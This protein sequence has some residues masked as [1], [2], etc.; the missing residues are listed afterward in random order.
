MYVLEYDEADDEDLDYARRS[1]IV[2]I[3]GEDAAPEMFF[4]Q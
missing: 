3:R 2:R 1:R 4:S